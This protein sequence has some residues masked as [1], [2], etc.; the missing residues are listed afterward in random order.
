MSKVIKHQ[1]FFRLPKGNSLGVS[2]EV[3]I[4]GAM[5]HEK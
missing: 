3:R 2:D 4:V 1:F 5:A